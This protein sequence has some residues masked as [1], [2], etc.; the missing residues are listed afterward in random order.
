MGNLF[1]S[2]APAPAPSAMTPNAQALYNIFMQEPGISNS[3]CNTQVQNFSIQADIAGV[4]TLPQSG[5]C[6]AGTT[7]Q[8]RGAGATCA[9]NAFA[10]GAIKNAPQPFQDSQQEALKCISKSLQKS[11]A[12]APSTSTYMPEPYGKLGGRYASYT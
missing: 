4:I 7:Q 1:S 12:P 8:G 11:P 6:P 9:P 2:T 5:Q 10:N 3:Q